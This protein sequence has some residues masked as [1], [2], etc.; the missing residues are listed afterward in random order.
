[1]TRLTHGRLGRLCR[2]GMAV[3]G[4]AAADLAS[5]PNVAAD[6]RPLV[7]LDFDGETKASMKYRDLSISAESAP[8]G[9]DAEMKVAVF[10]LQF[11]DGRRLDVRFPDDE[12]TAIPRADLRI[13]ALDR[14][15]AFPQVVLSY[16]WNGAHCCTMTKIVT[17]DGSN[18][19]IVVDAQTLDGSGYGFEDL[20]GDGSVELLSFDNSFNYAFA[21]Y[22]ESVAPVKVSKLRAGQL[23]DVTS[24]KPYRAALE[25]RLRDI[26]SMD[27]EN[28]KS[29]GYWGGWV[30]AKAQLGQFTEAWIAMLAAYDRSSDWSMQECVDY[31]PLEKCPKDKVRNLAF[32]EALAKHLQREGYIKLGDMREA[33][34]LSRSLQYAKPPQPRRDPSLETCVNGEDVVRRIIIGQLTGKRPA[35]GRESPAVTV[36]DVTL[37]GTDD[38]IGKKTCSAT[39]NV[40]LRALLSELAAKDEMRA[41][42]QLGKFAARKGG[43][44]VSRRVTYTVQPTAEP[45][46]IW[47]NVIR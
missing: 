13:Y 16:F 23:V 24:E 33:I 21:S 29:N 3:I 34:Q 7:Q 38:K 40:D 15:T 32:P 17:M 45:G 11:D 19:P 9:T 43:G 12:P 6:T 41:V 46:R 26:E 47:V 27:Q 35:E 2:L 5:S 44:Q 1:M 22:A 20:D 37:D 42:A 4:A 8:A 10:H 18:R 30:A 14:S 36:R 39:V 31:T 28:R 25:R